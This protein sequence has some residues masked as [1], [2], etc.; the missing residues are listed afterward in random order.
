MILIFTLFS[1]VFRR[2]KVFHSS[3]EKVMKASRAE[4]T[5]KKYNDAL[6]AWEVWCRLR[7][8][9]TVKP[10]HEDIAKYMI[11]LLRGRAVYAYVFKKM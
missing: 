1:F 11:D 2:N 6:A 4:S 3:L 7:H 8:V 10:T 5:I 9:S